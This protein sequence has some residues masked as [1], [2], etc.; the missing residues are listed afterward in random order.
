ML[1]IRRFGSETEYP[2]LLPDEDVRVTCFAELINYYSP[3]GRVM[4]SYP[5]PEEIPAMP[6]RLGHLYWPVF[7]A[8]RYAHAVILLDGHT[9]AK[10]TDASVSPTITDENGDG[11]DDEN[12]D[13]VI[14][15]E[16][17][18]GV[19]LAYR[20]E[21]EEDP[22]TPETPRTF[23]MFIA[24]V[25]PWV[26][27]GDR[28]LPADPDPAEDDAWI[29]LL[30]DARYYW[31]QS[32]GVDEDSDW[33][34]E[35]WE[36]LL[37]SLAANL[38]DDPP[39]F[40]ITDDPDPAY[41]TPTGR[42]SWAAMRGKPTPHLLDAAAANIGS[43]IVVLPDGSVSLQRPTTVN[44]DTA[45][46]AH[47][48]YTTDKRFHS[49]GPIESDDCVLTIPATAT[50]NFIG[51]D[52]FTF[53]VGGQSIGNR[54]AATFDIPPDAT[55]VEANALAT[56]WCEDF[57]NWNLVP[58][59]AVYAGFVDVPE[60]GFLSF[61]DVLHTRTEMRTRFGRPPVN[62]SPVYID[63]IG[64]GGGDTGNSTC[65]DCDFLFDRDALITLSSGSLYPPNALQVRI[66]PGAGR[67]ACIEG[68]GNDPDDPWMA[69]YDSVEDRWVLA[70][71]GETCCSCF[72]MKFA[73]PDP[74]D[75]TIS[76]VMA[77][78]KSCDGVTKDITFDLVF[79]GCCN[80]N[81]QP[82]ATLV[83]YGTDLCD[84][85][86]PY[87]CKNTFVV[88]VSCT[89][90]NLPVQPL[91]LDCL[92]TC[93][94]PVWRAVGTFSG[95]HDVYNGAWFLT[96]K[97]ETEPC[98]WELVCPDPD[99]VGAT[100][101]HVI[102]EITRV[103][104]NA[105]M[106]VTFSGG[107]GSAVYHYDETTYHDFLCF[108]P[109]TLTRDSG[110]ALKTPASITMTPFNC[111]ECPS[112]C[113]L[114]DYPTVQAEVISSSGTCG[115]MTLTHTG[116]TS[117]TVTFSCV[118]GTFFSGLAHLSCT[119]ETGLTFAIDTASGP[120]TVSV[121]TVSLTFDPFVWVVDVH[122]T[123]VSPPAPSPCDSTYRIVFT[124]GGT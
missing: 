81:G 49:G 12:G 44:R 27:T 14:G 105:R 46:T 113:T 77:V 1:T 31:L 119:P 11:I 88:E 82:T 53:S 28:P 16:A 22:M 36:E 108:T 21:A 98:K 57:Y 71:N 78:K 37:T 32:T 13:P 66:L 89:P 64:S 8:A 52:T 23:N 63:G 17:N 107:P 6:A 30:V 74:G 60:S 51:S 56:K 120:Y 87:P 83:G 70:R 9:L 95:D 35:T 20:D 58:L 45:S 97:G 38:S 114:I 121:T 41:L 18:N 90:C 39:P 118:I 34:P 7:G 68:Q 10:L 29:V 40:T 109:R 115:A 67:C 19:Q 102:A 99:I 112:K 76:G 26:K 85:D 50:I 48:D 24:G 3:A 62:Y 43:R 15:E 111:Q 116:D 33:I 79:Q 91:C 73:I 100:T 54:T 93:G 96:P 123:T 65:A 55:I 42:W 124:D 5:V 59:D 103:G 110:D 104:G 94:A 4:G 84:G 106:T 2:V 80:R 117:S 47:D 75:G 69:E 86:P 25:R 72:W 92:Q 61:A 122:F 101:V